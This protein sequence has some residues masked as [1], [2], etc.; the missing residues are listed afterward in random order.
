[1]TPG[2]FASFEA[3]TRA[4]ASFEACGLVYRDATTHEERYLPCR[5][6][7]DSAEE[8]FALDAE[9]WAQ[10]EDLGE[11]LAVCHSHPGTSRQPSKWD[12]AGC[13]ESGLPWLILGDDGLHR[14]DPESYALTGREFVFG[15]ADCWTLVRDWAGASWPEFPRVWG[16]VEGLFDAHMREMG[17]LEVPISDAAAGDVLLMRIRGSA[18]NHAAAYLGEGRIL[19]HQVG[20][21]S[22]VDQ[23]GPFLDKI[24]HVFRRPDAR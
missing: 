12:R 14:L 23:L 15:W 7:S 5:N 6:A 20:T 16:Q 8:E 9:D 13:N 22:G 2:T 19:H 24:T 1:M 3:H 4:N 17:W 21:L 10:A 18:T 11:V